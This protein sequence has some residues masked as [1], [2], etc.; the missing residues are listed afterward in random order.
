MYFMTMIENEYFI[1]L[2]PGKTGG[3]CEPT[4]TVLDGGIAINIEK[5]C[6]G[7]Q[8]GECIMFLSVVEDGKITGKIFKQNPPEYKQ[9]EKN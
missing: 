1:N 8:V 7:C 3:I 2:P 5:D 9:D 6:R 4:Q